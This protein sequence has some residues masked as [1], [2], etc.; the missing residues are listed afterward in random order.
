[1]NDRFVTHICPRGYCT[2]LRKQ[3]AIGCFYDFKKP[4]D[5]CLPGRVGVLCGKCKTGLAV[6]LQPER[7]TVCHKITGV[8]FGIFVVMTILVVLLII[9][10]NPNIAP[11]LRGILF[12]F[13]VMPFVVE[14]NSTV[15]YAV[16][17]ISGIS[18]FGRPMDHPLIPTCIMPGLG[19]LKA[20]ML[21]YTTPV[22]VLIILV[23]IY[24]FRAKFTVKRDKPFQC[25]FVLLVLVYKYC[26]ETSFSLLHC[27][28]VGGRFIHIFLLH[29][30]RLNQ[31]KS[32]YT[33]VK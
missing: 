18:D 16:T 12:Y 3:G 10:L 1:M 32:C 2:C 29:P 11:D 14:P 9:Y 19:N 21:N 24:C 4:N 20:N 13:Q 28:D 15:G 26:V 7:C 22:V 30:F 8:V 23:L 6:S 27:V 5:L 17:F 31:Y 25:F 33:S